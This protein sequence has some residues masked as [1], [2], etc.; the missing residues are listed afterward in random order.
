[1]WLLRRLR[2]LLACLPLA[3]AGGPALAAAPVIL[4]LGDSLSAE[5]GLPRDTG[6]VKLLERRLAEEKREYRVVNASISG[7]TTAGGRTRLPA[8]LAQHRPAIVIIELGGNDGL[9]GLSLST[10][11]ANLDAMVA[12]AQQTG[13]RVLM[14]GVRVPP[15]YGREY[16]ERFHAVFATVAKERKAALLPFLL[17]GFGEDLAYFQPDRIHPNERAQPRMLANVWPALTPLLGARR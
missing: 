3:F 17:E 14:V 5:Y 16:S 10:L 15:N 9:R 11:R 12:A 4:V 7:E 8:L 2:V 13:A 1:M 6:W